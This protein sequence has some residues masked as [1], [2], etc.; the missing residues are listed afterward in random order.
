MEHLG[1][2]GAEEAIAA[3]AVALVFSIGISRTA[4]P[5]RYY[6]LMT[7]V[8]F[9]PSPTGLLHVG[10]V[11]TGLFAWLFARQSNGT[12]ILRIEDTDQERSERKYEDLIY[13]DLRWLG[14]DWEEGPD[15][16]G[17]HGPTGSP[18]D[19]HIYK[20]YA[21]A[22]DR[23]RPRLLVFLFGGGARS[24]GRT[25]KGGESELEISGNLPRSVAEVVQSAAR[26]RKSRL[27]FV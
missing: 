17:P 19:S 20:D 13:E 27:S 9:A 4:D 15:V 24:S 26:T 8:R 6:C 22:P 18:N 21:P 3:E 11:R 5:A 25:G 7:R 12:Y 10:N 2:V 23:A 16:G 1:I 14:L